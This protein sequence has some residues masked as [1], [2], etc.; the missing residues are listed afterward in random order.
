MARHRT[1]EEKRELG[2]KARAMR[3]DGRSRRQIREAL[4]ISDD[5]AK[6]FLS[7][8]PVPESLRR[9]RA[10]DDL[11]AA[12][13][14]LRRAGRTYDDIAA[15]L[16]VSKSTCSLWLRDVPGTAGGSG[17]AVPS[18][19]ATAGAEQQPP[20]RPSP[21]QLAAARRQQARHLRQEDRLLVEIAAELGVSAKTVYYDTLGLPVPPRGRPR[22]R[23]AEDLRT[24]L[25]AYWERESARRRR[26][27]ERAEAG[28]AAAIAPM[29]RTELHLLAVTAYWCEGT[30]SKPYARREQ[31]T[32]IN[33]DLGLICLW[34][35]YLDDLRFPDEHRKIS[36][37]IH[38]SADVP[39][40]ERSWAEDIGVPVERFSRPTIKR[41]NPRT[42]R[43]NTE[44]AYRGCL[45][46]RLTQCADLY[47]RISGTWAGI[48]GALPTG[49]EVLVEG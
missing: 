43:R 16:G 21:Q 42:V 33:S 1:P 49:P 41:H 37:A 17:E 8:V 5:L 25:V 38:E 13:V 32:F 14:A 10:K 48:M 23:S 35:A 19:P 40:A 45:V 47:R 9:P 26:E 18:D 36:V 6:A 44:E 20:D 27:R 15:E 28:Y 39:A 24:D 7:G 31:V 29:T 30:K 4:G 11:H 3:A 22:G 34:L 46:V 12:A 2:E